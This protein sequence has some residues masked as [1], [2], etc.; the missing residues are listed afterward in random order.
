VCS[1]RDA[2]GGAAVR[3]QPGY[4]KTAIA[5]FCV[6]GAGAYF[7]GARTAISRREGFSGGWRK[8]GV[9]VLYGG[10]TGSVDRN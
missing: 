5:T 6:S 2:S 10:R 1:G 3:G 9:M 7:N 8:E 4:L